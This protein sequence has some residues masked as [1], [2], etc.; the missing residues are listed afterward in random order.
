MSGVWLVSRRGLVV[1][2]ALVVVLAVPSGCG[3]PLDREPQAL[4]PEGVPYNLLEQATTTTS[5]STTLPVPTVDVP[6]YF[7]LRGRL[8]EVQRGVTQS[9]SVNKAINALL[10]GPDDAEE[11]A[12]VRSAI[13]P[14]LDVEVGRVEQGVVTVDLGSEFSGLPREEQRLV[15]AQ[16]VWTAT[17][18]AGVTAVRF[19]LEGDDQEVVLPDASI[20]TGPVGR[21]AFASLCC[22]AVA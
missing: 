18:I 15:H 6:V 20:A 9:P 22:E 19:T 11:T 21:E 10:L 4:S 3:V 13:P 2:V 7:V 14:E 1:F 8:V 17:G 5:T 12:G 16:L